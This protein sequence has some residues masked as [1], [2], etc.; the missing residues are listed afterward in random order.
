MSVCKTEIHTK[1]KIL[2]EIDREKM[3]TFV[4]INVYSNFLACREIG[5]LVNV[6]EKKTDRIYRVCS[7]SCHG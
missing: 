4:V 3:T 1:R 6:L 2:E 5:C 7:N